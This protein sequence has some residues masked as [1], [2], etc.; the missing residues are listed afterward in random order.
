MVSHPPSRQPMS[1]LS[2]EVQQHRTAPCTAKQTMCFSKAASEIASIT[3][4]AHW[5][6][7][8]KLQ[9]TLQKILKDGNNNNKNNM[10]YDNEV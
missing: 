4:V 10:V 7:Y 1:T 8:L 6:L 2:A 3:P 9:A 5:A